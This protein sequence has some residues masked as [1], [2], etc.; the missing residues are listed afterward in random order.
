MSMTRVS[1]RSARP[2]IE[3]LHQMRLDRDLTYEQLAS[4][5]GMSM[6]N[7]FRLMNDRRASLQDRTLHK[8]RLH[9]ERHGVVLPDEP[10]AAEAAR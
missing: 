2:V 3:A 5:L 10:A 6:R 9:L 1:S 8:L 4:E 7:L